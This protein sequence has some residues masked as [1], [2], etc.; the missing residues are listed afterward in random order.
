MA[1]PPHLINLLQNLLIILL[2]FLNDGVVLYDFRK[3]LK[4]VPRVVRPPG[5]LDKGMEG[6]FVYFRVVD[7]S[8]LIKKCL[9]HYLGS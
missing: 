3:V 1:R 6:H 8:V 9:K 7:E 4:W 5:L 2:Y